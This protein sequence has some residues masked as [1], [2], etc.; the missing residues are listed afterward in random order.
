MSEHRHLYN[1]AAWK[2]ARAVQLRAHPLCRMHLELG[3]TVVATVVDHITAHRGDRVLFTDRDNLQSLCKPC[4]DGHKQA[5]EHSPG[6]LVR[7]AGLT[8]TPLD[9][10]HPWHQPTRGGVENS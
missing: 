1:T 4:H 8:G 7:G 10:A 5:Q 3:Q 2:R 9:R 6:G